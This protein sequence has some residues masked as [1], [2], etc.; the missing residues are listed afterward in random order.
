MSEGEY[1]KMSQNAY[2][3]GV[4]KYSAEGAIDRFVN[5][6]CCLHCNAG[7]TKIFDVDSTDGRKSC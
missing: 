7:F 2:E 5:S 6:N 4:K 3:Y 1:K